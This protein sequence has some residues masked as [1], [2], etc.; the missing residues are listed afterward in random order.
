MNREISEKLK[1][2]KA[3]VFD[4][5][6]VLFSENVFFDSEKGEVLRMRSHHDGQGVNL[7][8]GIG[9][10]VAFITSENN[11]FLEKLGDKLNNSLA[12]KSGKFVPIKIFSGSLAENKED[13]IA[14][15]LKE[16]GLSFDEC[17]YMGDDIGDFSIM[18][19]VGFP[20]APK[21]ANYVVR[22]LSLIEINKEGGAGAVREFCDMIL[23]AKGIS[24]I[25]LSLK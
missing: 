18:K 15:W 11:G 14:I 16:L 9:I 2:I 10:K 13:V 17:S 24:P 20:V 19:K 3:V 23:F 8:R 5:V 4:S 6:G 25:G 1:N 21:N 22:D 12:V 7:L